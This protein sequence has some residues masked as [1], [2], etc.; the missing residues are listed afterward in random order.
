MSW[1]EG[2]VE[3]MC[4]VHELLCNLQLLF[5]TTLSFKKKAEVPIPDPTCNVKF[6]NTP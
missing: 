4:Q 5:Q 2:T 6:Q 3:G 1:L